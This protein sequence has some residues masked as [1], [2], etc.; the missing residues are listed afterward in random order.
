[1]KK[2]P[3]SAIWRIKYPNMVGQGII[4]SGAGTGFR[5]TKTKYL[6]SAFSGDGARLAEGRWNRV[7]SRM[8]YLGSSLSLVT[9]EL[10]SISRIT[11]RS[12]D[13]SIIFRSR[14]IEN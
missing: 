3:P 4:S 14:L 5:I 6:E 2:I 7:D 9:L 12:C 11:R 8:V 13:S 1:M 10:L